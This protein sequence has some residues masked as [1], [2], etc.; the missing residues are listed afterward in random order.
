MNYDK[1]DPEQYEKMYDLIP[2]EIYMKE[3][4]RSLIKK[5]IEKYCKDKNILDLDCGTGIYTTIIKKYADN[6]LGLDISKRWLNYLKNKK[7]ISNIMKAD[8]HNIP[9]KKELFDVIL[10]I[11]L[12][13]YIHREIVI[14]EMNRI[15]KSGGFCIVLVPNKYSAHRQADRIFCNVFKR[16]YYPNEPSKKEMLKL[17]EN[18]EF[19]LIEP[20]IR[21]K[22]IPPHRK[23]FFKK[24]KYLEENHL[25]M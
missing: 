1:V 21:E 14:K 22:D 17:F 8:A 13:E 18:I 2:R 9:L 5:A 23:L 25:V 15:L 10:T 11:S 24:K 3:H 6:V 20:I 19:K 7:S 16:K 4:R 12:F